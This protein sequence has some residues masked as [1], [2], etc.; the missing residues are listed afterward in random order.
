VAAVL[1]RRR[2]R[3][4]VF[5]ATTWI[6]EQTFE[7]F[8][9]VP[10]VLCVMESWIPGGDIVNDTNTVHGHAKAPRYNFASMCPPFQSYS[11]H[12]FRNSRHIVPKF[13]THDALILWINGLSLPGL[14]GAD[15]TA[16][17]DGVSVAVKRHVCLSFGRTSKR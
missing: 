13:C 6:F 4:P 16:S 10:E 14:G 5:F 17:M 11:A 8:W 7:G 2:P 15:A 12:L 3:E 1:A 9:P